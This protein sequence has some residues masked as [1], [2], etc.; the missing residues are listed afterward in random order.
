MINHVEHTGN[1]L[2]ISG[3]G[4][5]SMDG[6]ILAW[7]NF[8]T[9]AAGD[10]IPQNPIIGTWRKFKST[11]N[12]WTV[13]ALVDGSL[14]TSGTKSMW[15][16]RELDD[17]S[18]ASVDIPELNN[19]YVSAWLRFNHQG[20]G[21]VKL[22]Q[23]KGTQGG[24]CQDYHPIVSTGDVSA[25]WWK[26]Y[27]SLD[28]PVN[29]YSDECS[30]TDPYN[31][32][33]SQSP[34]EDEWHYYEA[35]LRQSTPGEWDGSVEIRMDGERQFYDPGI[36]TRVGP[37]EHWNLVQLMNGMTN[38]DSSN[39]WIDDYYVASTHARVLVCDSQQMASCHI[40]VPVSWSDTEIKVDINSDTYSPDKYVYVANS[41]NEYSNGF[42]SG[43]G[44]PETMTDG[45]VYCQDFE[46]DAWKDDFMNGIWS[47]QEPD[48]VARV[49]YEPHSGSYAIRGNLW[50]DY[51]DPI[52]NVRG[53]PLLQFNWAPDEI[54]GLDQVFVRHYFRVDDS[55]WNGIDDSGNV[56]LDHFDGKLMYITDANVGT[57]AFFV[58]MPARFFQF[59][60]ADSFEYFFQ[61]QPYPWGEYYDLGGR[62]G[63]YGGGDYELGTDG[64]WHKFELHVDHVN[65]YLE[66]WVDGEKFIPSNSDGPTDGKIP[67]PPEFELRGYSFWYTRDTF[68]QDSVDGDGYAGSWEIDDI[69]AWDH[70][71]GTESMTL[72]QLISII[73]SWRLGQKT[74]QQVMEAIQQ[75]KT[76]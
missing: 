23:V 24:S 28:E 29:I 1:Q 67:V 15:G 10:E 55:T 56:I 8:E 65:D 37:D 5:G 59:N 2:I 7:D 66:F 73:D 16:H 31:S 25:G 20:T 40:Q 47:I 69:M 57:G 54:R 75:W 19:L 21:Q 68:M 62:I 13:T 49:A 70:M 71:P 34:S 64:V 52:T 3:S 43:L 41:D 53:A 46:E 39:T 60:G 33:Y 22:M 35:I 51:I 44:C 9:Y 32:E 30:A 36:I 17:W 27:V 42:V 11:D 76:S 48:L 61:Q 74:I 50:S 38:Y 63:M 26:T 14:S 6:D 72:Q 18:G 45:M 12:D 4:F 58:N